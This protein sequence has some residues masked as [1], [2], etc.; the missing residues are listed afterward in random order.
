MRF[1]QFILVFLCLSLSFAQDNNQINDVETDLKNARYDLNEINKARYGSE[2]MQAYIKKALTLKEEIAKEI[3]GQD[4]IA[5]ILQHKL[6]QV[7]EN[8]G[9]RKRD[10]VAMHLIGL[11]GIGKSAILSKI[12]QVTGIKVFTIE[13]QQFSDPDNRWQL[14]N[15]LYEASQALKTGPA[16]IIFDEV[17][18]VPEIA[19]GLNSGVESTQYLI[20]Y[21]NALLTDG[22]IKD[23]RTVYD[24]SNALVVSA[25]N[26]A[27]EE[28]ES[29]STEILGAEKNFFDYTVEDLKKFHEWISTKPSAR[30]KVLSKLFR[31]NTVGR[32]GPNVSIVK[33][34][35]MDDY[36]EIVKANIE[37][38]IKDNLATFIE[39]K[40]KVSYTEDLIDFFTSVAV[41]PPTG[42]RMTVFHVKNFI[43][44]LIN[45]GTKARGD[46]EESLTRP[47]HLLLDY[48]V[49]A[50]QTR[51]E[52]TPMSFYRQQWNFKEDQAFDF[53]VEYDEMN[54]L[55]LRPEIVEDMAPE[56][57]DRIEK[58]DV[59]TKK[60]IYEAR[61]PKTGAVKEEIADDINRH[62]IGQEQITKLIEE[63][64]HEFASRPIQ[65]LDRPVFSLMAGFPGIGKSE[66]AKLTAKYTGL[67][68]V[69]LN[70]Q[71]YQA[72]EG[73]S[74]DKFL[75]D[76]RE[77]TSQFGPEDRYVLLIEELDKV[78]EINP[79]NGAI[80]DRPVMSAIKELLNSGRLE[81]SITNGYSS[82][83][84][85]ID[86]RNA[87]TFVTMN[88]GT[89]RFHFEADPRLTSI[90]DVM[91][92]WH[93]MSGTLANK[94][95]VFGS[96]FL[97]ETVSRMINNSFIVKPLTH[98]EYEKLIRLTYENIVNKKFTDPKTEKNLSQIFTEF[99]SEYRN[100]LFSEGVIPSEGARNTVMTV[101]D[102]VGQDL[103]YA[104][105][106]IPKNSRL[107]RNPI[108]LKFDF[109]PVTSESDEPL[110]VAK[111]RGADETGPWTNLFERKVVLRFPSPELYGKVNK[112]RLLTSIHEFGHAY[113]GVRLGARIRH[114]VTYSPKAG[115]G[116]FVS[117]TNS[118]SNGF[119]HSA[120]ELLRSIYNGLAARAMEKIFLSEDPLSASA[121][122]QI[123][124]GASGDITQV[125]KD[126]Y[127]LLKKL[128][129]DPRGV[130]YDH[131]EGAL[132]S[133]TMQR[134]HQNPAA[135]EMERMG[136]ILADM[137]KLIIEDFLKAH[138]RA[139]YAER[140]KEIAK[141]GV[142]NEKEF[143]QLLGYT[144]PGEHGEMLG[145]ENNL[146]GF[147]DD[148]V[149]EES[150]AIK[151]AKEF[152][153]GQTQTTAK[154]NMKRFSEEFE[155]I[156]KKNYVPKKDCNKLFK[157]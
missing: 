62:I 84:V 32:L 93:M 63:R 73:A 88:F 142:M 35:N 112:A 75:N 129:H 137:E 52:V 94:K 106:N 98:Y 20:G 44:Y 15:I 10:P 130:I 139:W 42:A 156:L 51:I 67:K 154:E 27:S 39:R 121:N 151:M 119:G 46:E 81:K 87:F 92:A 80:V 69:Q 127:F 30:N 60:Q 19:Q 96:L 133:A 109:K 11:P 153:Q 47:R 25:M 49:K 28:I 77:K 24:L 26:F 144:Y 123:R 155:K 48:D 7:L 132:V 152:K 118:H 65:N 128:G 34:L 131:Q 37:N 16:V 115:I 105:K 21:L 99:T 4:E 113:M 5:T 147:F 97:P 14:N 157:K 124:S 83:Y 149:Q 3:V 50:G 70:M 120:P 58:E 1:L 143:Y 117:Y 74:V 76:L 17:D 12:E 61:F 134:G 107:T 57:I 79:Q 31:P 85:Q 95:S 38:S 122:M 103:E 104:L 72:N 110:V 41:D 140:I 45:Y 22:K 36:R 138:D 90:D 114:V 141:R 102:I 148:I 33:P 135:E 23:G 13:A 146:G 64:F 116:G 9:S 111:I 82:R 53:Y 150:D 78:Y 145:V 100:Y 40:L 86:I 91:N 29:F 8:F 71:D 126:L 101:Q 56:K 18:K 43:N 2:E 54:K 108:V 66:I 125:S 136:R 6:I 89:D 59:I 68:V 55:F